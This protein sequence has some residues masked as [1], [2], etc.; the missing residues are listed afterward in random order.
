MF[1][2][3]IEKFILFVKNIFDMKHCTDHI[4]IQKCNFQYDIQ[5]SI[6]FLFYFV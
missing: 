4:E 1:S 6:R 5:Q 2:P 3:F